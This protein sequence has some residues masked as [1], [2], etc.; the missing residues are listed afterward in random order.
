MSGGVLPMKVVINGVEL[1]TQQSA[2]LQTAVFGF[3]KWL[4]DT[5]RSQDEMRGEHDHARLV[6]IEALLSKSPDEVK[7]RRVK[8]NLDKPHRCPQCHKIPDE[9]Q[10]DG[11]ALPGSGTRARAATS[12]GR[13]QP[14]IRHGLF[15]E[16]LR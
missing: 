4:Q 14:S 11:R 13:P 9:A 3:R 15:D 5:G 8:P 2:S 12:T 7:A 16:R 6:E 1:T 10:T